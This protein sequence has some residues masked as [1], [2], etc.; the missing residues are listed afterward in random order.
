MTLSRVI[1]DFVPNRESHLRVFSGDSGAFQGLSQ[2]FLWC[3]QSSQNLPESNL[4]RESLEI[5]KNLKKNRDRE[6]LISSGNK[7]PNHLH[8][9]ARTGSAAGHDSFCA[10]LA[11]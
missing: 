3:F 5:L 10:H 1:R 4:N 2:T 6:S 7:Y 11:G 8:S 9:D